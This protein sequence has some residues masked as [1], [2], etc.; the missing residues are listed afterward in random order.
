MDLLTHPLVVVEIG[1]VAALVALFALL[2]RRVDLRLGKLH[3]ELR[4]NGG[5]STRDVIDRIERKVDHTIERVAVLEHATLA[6]VPPADA[7]PT[8][9]VEPPPPPSRE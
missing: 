2:G 3:A 8:V 9:I 4:P 1:I 6:V 5:T 7:A